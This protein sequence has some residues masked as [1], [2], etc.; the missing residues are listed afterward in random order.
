MNTKVGKIAKMIIDDEAP[1]TPLQKK[2]AEIGKNFGRD[3]YS[4]FLIQTAQQNK[5]T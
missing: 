3:D 4:E 2:L 1:Q 5:E